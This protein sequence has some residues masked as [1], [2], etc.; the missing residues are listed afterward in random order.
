MRATPAVLA[1]TLLAFGC[2]G[3]ELPEPG[4]A[5]VATA[6]GVNLTAADLLLERPPQLSE[7]ASAAWA[8]RLIADWHQKRT[9]VHLAETELPE[10]E[11]N[12]DREVA[13]YREAL[14]IHAYE[15]RYLRQHLDTAVTVDEMAAF[16]EAQPGLFPLEAPLFRARWVV[17]PDG[18]PFPRD[19]RDVSKQLASSDAEVLSAL[20]SRCADAGLSFD[21]DAERWW[22]W[23][24]LGAVVPLEPRKAARLQTSQRVSKIEWKADTSAGRPLDQRAL[25]LVTDRLA[26]GAD[27]PV[28]RV[29]D[30]ISELLLHRRRNLTL[31]NMRQ[32]AVQAAWAEAALSNIYRIE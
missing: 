11:R 10:A 17:F 5:V 15:D 1:A 13:Q 18:S 28:E 26:A 7:A 9:L 21:L 25:L 27:S 14:F 20:S 2:K 8:E 31:S 19:W 12:F 6:Y 32:Q 16:L 22:T 4:S 30:R 3:P 23:E 29:A 24:E